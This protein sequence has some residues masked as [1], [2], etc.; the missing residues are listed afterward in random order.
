M[1]T[2]FG[3]QCFATIS[4]LYRCVLYLFLHENKYKNLNRSRK[5]I[6]LLL[7]VSRKFAVFVV[8]RNLSLALIRIW[9]THLDWLAHWLIL[10]Y[11]FSQFTLWLLSK[12]HWHCNT[13]MPN[14]K[15]KSVS[16]RSFKLKCACC[17][18]NW[19]EKFNYN[20]R[21][22]YCK[23]V[24]SKWGFIQSNNTLQCSPTCSDSASLALWLA[25]SS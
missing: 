20:Q 8:K 24:L 7:F 5:K 14:L 1:L 4:S 17:K 15:S 13:D 25:N 10:I 3:S 12:A 19:V 9:W 23:W 21:L 18:R 16:F 6:E 22:T 11:W 2:R